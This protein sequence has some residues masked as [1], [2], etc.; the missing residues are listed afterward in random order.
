MATST[1]RRSSRDS[2]IS[3]GMH[4]MG[5]AVRGLASESVGALRDRAGEYVEHGR[6]RVR[7]IG[8]TVESRIQEKPLKSVLVAAGIGLLI[9]MFCSRR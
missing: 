2:S 7:E 4:E 3:D 8:D 5:A 6:D 1:H 9:G